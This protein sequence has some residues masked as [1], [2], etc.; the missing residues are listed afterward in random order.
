MT[1]K[2]LLLTPIQGA[3]YQMTNK[4]MIIALTEQGCGHIIAKDVNGETIIYASAPKVELLEAL[5]SN[6]EFDGIVIEYTG[7]YDCVID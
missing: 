4:Q 5:C 1:K 3:D 7:V 2:Y 6:N